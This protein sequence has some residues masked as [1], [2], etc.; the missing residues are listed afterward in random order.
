MSHRVIPTSREFTHSC[1]SST[2]S[3]H[4][5]ARR[6][7]EEQLCTVATTDTSLGH[8]SYKPKQG[9][10]EYKSN[11]LTTIV[12]MTLLSNTNKSCAI[13]W[14]L[15]TLHHLTTRRQVLLM[16]CSDGW[17]SVGL[18]NGRIC[19]FTVYKRPPLNSRRRKNGL[20]GSR[21]FIKSLLTKDSNNYMSKFGIDWNAKTKCAKTLHFTLPRHKAVL[22]DV[23]ACHSPTTSW[24]LWDWLPLALPFTGRK[25]WQKRYVPI[26]KNI[27]KWSNVN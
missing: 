2:Q 7:N 4:P 21:E 9:T 20:C 6:Q 10:Q 16:Q 15:E 22:T 26:C 24:R 14:Y 18:S 5:F 27:I 11:G 3:S 17:R 19:T 12:V 1:S 23:K 25:Q 8:T 13:I